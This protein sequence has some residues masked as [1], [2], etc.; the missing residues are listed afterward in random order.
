MDAGNFLSK[1]VCPHCYNHIFVSFA[2]DVKEKWMVIHFKN[3]GMELKFYISDLVNDYE[4]DDDYGS[5]VCDLEIPPE[6]PSDYQW[7]CGVCYN[8]LKKQSQEDAKYG[9]DDKDN[10]LDSLD[11]W[12]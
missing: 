4:N 10:W 2:K 8:K 6:L 3:G 11:D 5:I 9:N 7:I 12:R 1:G